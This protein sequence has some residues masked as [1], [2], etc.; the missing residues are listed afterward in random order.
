MPTPKTRATN[1]HLME[2]YPLIFDGAM[3]TMIEAVADAECNA[4]LNVT[5]PDVIGSIHDA[6]LNAGADIISTNTFGASEIALADYDLAE[7]MEEINRAAVS[8]AKRSADKF[9]KGG[10]RCFVAGEVGPTSKLPTLGHISYDEIFGAYQRQIAALTEAG[11]D[12]ILIPTCQDVLQIKAA[13][14]V[15]S[16]V[17]F[18]VSVTIEKNGTMLLGTDITAALAAVEPFGPAAFGINCATGPEMMEE[19]I[20]ELS[21]HSPFPILCRPNA[22]MPENVG[23]RSVYSLSPAEFASRLVGFVEQFGVAFVGG[24]CGTTPDHIKALSGILKDTRPLSIGR[25]VPGLKSQVSSLFSAVALDQEPKPFLVAEQ[26]NVNGSK[27]FKELLLKDDY[28]SMVAMAKDAAKGAHAIDLCVAYPGRDEAADMI[29]VVS[30]AAKGVDSPLMIDSTNPKVI[31]AALKIAPGRCIINSINLEDGGAR[32]KE[33]IDLAKKFGAALICLTIDE[34]GMARTASKKAE[35]ARRIYDLAVLKGLRA[36]DLIFDALTFTVASGDASSKDAA[37][38]TLGGIKKIKKEIKDVRTILGISNVSFGLLPQARSVVTSVFLNQAV[39]AGLDAAI[40]NSARILRLAEISKKELELATRLL[41]N[42]DSKGEPLAA[43][44][45]YFQGI[46]EAP[47]R[48][49]DGGPVNGPDALRKK[50]MDGDKSGLGPLLEDLCRTKKPK[51][52]LNRILL[53][54]MKDIGDL[55]GGGKLPLPF[56]LQSAEAM[57]AAVD[58]LAPK[59]KEGEAPKRGT[60]VLATVRGDVHD[61]GKNLVDIILSNNGFE[62]INLGIRQPVSAILEAA[63]GNGA[64]AIGLSGLLVSSTEIM[65]EDLQ[66]LDHQGISMP[67]LVGGAALTKKF[68]DTTLKKSYRGPVYYCEDAFAGLKAMEEITSQ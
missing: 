24:C 37:I 12:Y 23:G 28:D 17:P 63:R 34:D 15:P 56:V 33:I 9:S 8:I 60:I 45:K 61:I 1:L 53:P 40:V 30:R 29:E 35:I 39:F 18:L 4:L 2:K 3:G 21:L 55:F 20:H 7:R 5:R 68:T 59:L 6:Y 51:D 38:Q 31:E 52:I 10:R 25:R 48:R 57:R 44:I 13:T 36:G 41:E 11:V 58:L 27:K 19:H 62:V 32:A 65:R 54:A 47:V 16:K 49:G 64:D 22:G 66:S 26:T 14:A 43:L 46:V 50:I 67:V 42:D